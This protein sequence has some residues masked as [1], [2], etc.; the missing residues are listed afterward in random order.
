[1]KIE[2]FGTLS[3]GE[4][5]SLITIRNQNGMT[6]VLTDVGAS[7]VKLFVP[8]RDGNFRDVVLGY[9]DPHYYEINYSCFGATVGPIANRIAHHRFTLNGQEYLLSPWGGRD[10]MLHCFPESYALRKWN[11]E[12]EEDPDA[13]SV[14]FYL[15]SPDGEG[16]LPGNRDVSVTYTL[17]DDNDLMIRYFS[18]SDK[19]TL[20][21][22]TNHSYFNL[23][24]HDS[25]SA[26][27]QYLWMDSDRIAVEDE[28]QC[29]TGDYLPVEGTVYD[30]R[31]EKV[32]GKDFRLKTDDDPGF[33]GYDNAFVVNDGKVL[34]EARLTACMRS[35]ESGIRMEVYTDLPSIQLYTAN[36]RSDKDLM[37]NPGKGVCYG[38]HAGIALETQYVPN[39]VNCGNAAV[40]LLRAGEEMVSL[41]V[42]RFT[43]E[44]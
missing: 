7:L 15:F 2:T 11:I 34:E 16:G 33:P 31:K 32:I 5:C 13:Q 30:F 27:G 29:P 24:G 44:E 22:L 3:S 23:N 25:G 28:D 40:P 10:A 6:A 26:A 18:L 4:S 9:D 41:T 8:D 14:T 39:A 43:V 17:T 12:P 21:N 19:D 20:M 38:N 1:M 35:A 36:L 42:Y 37:K